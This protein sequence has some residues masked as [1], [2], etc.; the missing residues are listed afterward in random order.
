MKNII[1]LIAVIM[2]FISGHYQAYAQ[3]YKCKTADGATVYQQTGCSTDA[4]ET[5]IKTMKGPTLTEAEKFNAAAYAA[6]MT[7]KEALELLDGRRSAGQPVA[8]QPAK[9][10]PADK[11][12]ELNRVEACNER[13]DK[14]ARHARSTFTGPKAGGNLSRNLQSIERDRTTCLFGK[15][16]VT[17]TQKHIETPSPTHTPPPIHIPQRNI[18]QCM[19]NCA[20]QQ[21]ICFANCQGNGI[22]IANCA[23]AHGRCSGF[24]TQ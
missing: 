13:Y 10:S 6:G 12:A 14:L 7:P 5:Q 8:A 17:Q 9:V 15:N 20:S 18:G 16:A 21:G 1:R 2:L 24:C 4:V 19:G 23:S 22:C 11:L 3:V